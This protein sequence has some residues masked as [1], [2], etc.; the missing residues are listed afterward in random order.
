MQNFAGLEN[1]LSKIR[2]I[3][4]CCRRK[5]STSLV[6][7]SPSPF[8]Y[9]VKH[10]NWKKV[11]WKVRVSENTEYILGAFPSE[12]WHKLKS[13]F[14]STVTSTVWSLGKA[15]GKIWTA[16]ATSTLANSPV[17]QQQTC[18]KKRRALRTHPCLVALGFPLALV[19]LFGRAPLVALSV[20]LKHIFQFGPTHQES[21]CT[22]QDCSK[23]TLKLSKW[24]WLGDSLKKLWMN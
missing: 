23:T 15:R 6:L 22:L 14:A 18:R 4:L 17:Q 2:M 3:V 9:T 12:K 1:S 10:L 8:L 19:G 16:L 13:T 7:I 5:T 21:V 24:G 20:L 11:Y